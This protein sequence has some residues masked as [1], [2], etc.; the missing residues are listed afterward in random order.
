MKNSTPKSPFDLRESQKPLYAL[1]DMKGN[2]SP[3][4]A[5]SGNTLVICYETLRE[6]SHSEGVLKSMSFSISQCYD[7]VS[8]SYPLIRE[9]ELEAFD[10][11]EHGFTIEDI[12][13]VGKSFVD[14][15][16]NSFLDDEFKYIFPQ[17][18][19]QPSSLILHLP[20]EIWGY[21]GKDLIN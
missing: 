20:S 6:S 16:Y 4:E 3:E 11:P 2:I 1:K 15:C 8:F 9:I 14:R 17:A 18:T 7:T 19:A 5:I 13:K 12:S 21:D 10:P